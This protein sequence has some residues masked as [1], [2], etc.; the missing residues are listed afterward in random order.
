[1]NQLPKYQNEIKYCGYAA[2]LSG[3]NGEVLIKSKL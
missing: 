1:M 3:K 2:Y